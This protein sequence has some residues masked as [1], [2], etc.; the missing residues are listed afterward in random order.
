MYLEDGR[1]TP[2][3]ELFQRTQIPI[4]L[5]A[6]VEAPILQDLLRL[7]HRIAIHVDPV[8]GKGGGCADR[9]SGR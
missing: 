1:Y 4:Q 8:G 9:D 2:A 6:D 5:H 7:A 3:T